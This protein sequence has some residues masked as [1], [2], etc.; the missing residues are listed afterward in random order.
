[1]T[2]VSEVASFKVSGITP[3]YFEKII[4]T[5]FDHV[6]LEL[7]IIES[8]GDTR[9]PKDWFSVPYNV[10][11]DVI[12]LIGTGEIVNFVYDSKRKQLISK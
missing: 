12:R 2:E 9:R 8:K 11:E 4:H 7:E 6:R 10:I 1:M 5:L 3:R